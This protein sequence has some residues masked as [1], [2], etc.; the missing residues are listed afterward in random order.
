MWTLQELKN[1]ISNIINNISGTSESWNYIQSKNYCTNNTF[2]ENLAFKD[3]TESI[4]VCTVLEL[5]SC[6]RC[7]L[8]RKHNV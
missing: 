7:I 8:N 5:I 2:A 1:G 4:Y 6:S 3:F